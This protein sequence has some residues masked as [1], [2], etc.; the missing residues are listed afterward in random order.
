M[1]A[2]RAYQITAIVDS[3]PPKRSVRAPLLLSS[4]GSKVREGVNDSTRSSEQV[5]GAA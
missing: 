2:P 3:S 4:A 1:A 5:H